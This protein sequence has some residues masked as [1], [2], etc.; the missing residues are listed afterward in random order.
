[1]DSKEDFFLNRLEGG[2]FFMKYTPR[3]F[4]IGSDVP[5][6]IYPGLPAIFTMI[7]LV[8]DNDT[9]PGLLSTVSARSHRR[10]RHWRHGR[11]R[12]RPPCRCWTGSL[13]ADQGSGCTGG[14]YKVPGPGKGCCGDGNFRSHLRVDNILKHLSDVGHTN[15]LLVSLL[16]G[17]HIF[18][19]W[20]QTLNGKP[21][22][23]AGVVLRNSSHCPSRD[24]FKEKLD[25]KWFPS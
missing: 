2:F 25:L 14:C 7:F 20:K 18:H 15:F 16:D 5:H 11:E 8:W 17:K 23:W 12:R 22:F 13:A 24:S 10:W 21:V 19:V 3:S 9:S 4:L 6:F 1:M